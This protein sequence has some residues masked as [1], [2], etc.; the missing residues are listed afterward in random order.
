[1]SANWLSSGP[2]GV[3]GMFA[4]M[5]NDLTTPKILYCPSEYRST[6]VQAS[7]F[8]NSTAT[9][10]GFFNDNG[11]SYFVGVDASDTAP[12]MFLTGDHHLGD[13]ATPPSFPNLFG[14]SRPKFISAGTNIAWFSTSIGWANVQHGLKG[15]VCFADGSVQTLDTT[16]LRISLNRTGD[17]GRSAGVFNNTVGTSGTGVNRLQFP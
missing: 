16:Q 17:T 10:Q 11:T 12:Q 15:N 7:I 5:S 4:V 1:M 13:G 14:D 9:N 3:F 8:G 6:I 2:Y